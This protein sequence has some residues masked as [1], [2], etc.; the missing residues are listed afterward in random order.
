MIDEMEQIQRN[1]EDEKYSPSR[2]SL[3][4]ATSE[5][6]REYHKQRI[7]G[8]KKFQTD[9]EI[10]FNLTKHPKRKKLF[11]IAWEMGHSN[12]FLEVSQYYQ[13]FSELL[14]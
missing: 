7:A 6:I 14:S 5:Q 4:G 1:V 11:V 13:K 9:L 10:M 12:G 2:K 8:Q 3:K